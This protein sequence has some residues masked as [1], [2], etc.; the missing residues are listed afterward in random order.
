[1]TSRWTIWADFQDRHRTLENYWRAVILFGQNVASY[2][3]A[4]AES[5]I[6]LGDGQ[7]L[8]MAAASAS[9]AY[10]P[11]CPRVTFAEALPLVCPRYGRQISRLSET[12]R[13]V[14]CV[15]GG[16]AG[17]RLVGEARRPTPPASTI[18]KIADNHRDRAPSNA[19]PCRLHTLVNCPAAGCRVFP[20]GR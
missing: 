10:C 17:A 9:V 8:I 5:L 19:F 13:L 16:E 14:G 4:L 1:M 15:L 11:A 7:V 3:L 2:K 6:D 20:N 18:Y 12:I